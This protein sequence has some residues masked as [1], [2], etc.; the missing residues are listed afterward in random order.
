MREPT[1]GI[2][3]GLCRSVIN[4]SSTRSAARSGV[5]C[6]SRRQYL[7]LA[8]LSARR[9]TALHGAVNTGLEKRSL[10]LAVERRQGGFEQ[11]AAETRSADLADRRTLRFVP[12]EL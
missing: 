4:G 12:S 7:P 3:G 8:H 6:E 1:I 9:H 11:L 2:G 5:C 10:R